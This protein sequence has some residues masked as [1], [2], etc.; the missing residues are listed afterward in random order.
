MSQFS[1]TARPE[2]WE[3]QQRLIQLF[4]DFDAQQRLLH[5]LVPSSLAYQRLEREQAKTAAAI[6][7]TRQQRQAH[8]N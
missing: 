4:R 6:E 5:Y 7:T 8:A 3:T 1:V 2:W